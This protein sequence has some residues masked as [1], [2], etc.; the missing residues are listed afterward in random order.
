MEE[1]S[2]SVPHSSR[3]SN[4]AS[5][6]PQ[7]RE[8]MLEAYLPLVRLVAKKF[9]VVSHRGLT[10][11]RWFTRGSSAYWKPCSATTQAVG[12][13][14]RPMRATASRARL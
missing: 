3:Q 9:T 5:A 12:W 6:S 1:I 14:F 13:R 4:S 10:S 2:T 11:G 8:E 7:D